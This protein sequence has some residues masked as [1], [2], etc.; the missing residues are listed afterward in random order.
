MGFDVSYHPISEAEIYEW[1]F[2]KLNNREA[3]RALA[4]R[5]GMATLYADKY[6]DILRIG[7]Q[8]EP[9]ELFEKA[10]GLYIAVVQG[11]FRRYFYTRGA[12]FTFLIEAD[13]AFR[14]YTKPWADILRTAVPN[15]AKSMIIE[16][17]SSGVFIPPEQVKQLLS[18]YE[19]VP[20]AKAKLDET[21]SHG[22][23]AVFLKAA[24]YAAENGLGLLEA[25]EVVEP[26]PLNL[27]KSGSYSN[28]LNC[29]TEG[30][31]LYQR[32]TVAQLQAL[33]SRAPATQP[34]ASQRKKR[35]FSKLF[36]GK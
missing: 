23:I 31:L 8:T 25:T 28:L 20:E 12:A 32:E 35:F 13:A 22:R 19:Q 7:A 29:D 18:D 3:A 26:D 2:D 16:N 15:P 30:P 1:Y 14:R 9:D 4:Q 6:L 24:R 17:Y 5:H 10:H 33:Q 27:N 34:Q 21:F 36:G 11:F